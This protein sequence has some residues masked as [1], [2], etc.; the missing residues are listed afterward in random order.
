MGLQSRFFRDVPQLEASAV[1][2]PSHIQQGAI[3]DH[4]SLIQQALVVLDGAHIFRSELW[5]KRYG[6]S[7]AAA[8]LRYKKKRG[9]INRSYQ[10]QA[11]NIVGKMTM[12][13]LDK[14][15]LRLERTITVSSIH[16]SFAGEP[17]A[18]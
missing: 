2:D 4:V 18:E 10:T 13:A 8:V 7:T 11:Y 5:A 14:E 3:G 15:M 6:P 17:G 9:I 1:S 12:A 16:C